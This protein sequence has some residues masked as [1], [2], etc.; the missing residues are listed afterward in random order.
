[1]GDVQLNKMFGGKI[2]TEKRNSK[3][4]SH[5]AENAIA[6]AVDRMAEGPPTVWAPPRA[7]A[8]PEASGPNHRAGREVA[9]TQHGNRDATR[10]KKTGHAQLLFAKHVE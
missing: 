10:G 4:P 3:S 6:E 9:S 1:M 8:Q 5:H 2:R 7:K